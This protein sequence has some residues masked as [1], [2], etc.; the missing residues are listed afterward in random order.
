ML[1]N[2]Q[3]P[4]ISQYPRIFYQNLNAY[5]NAQMYYILFYPS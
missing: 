2:A 5:Q 3:N 1:Y 4:K